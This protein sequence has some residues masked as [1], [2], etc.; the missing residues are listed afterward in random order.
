MTLGTSLR[1]LRQ[2][3]GLSLNELAT[4]LS[5][6][7]GNLS[8]IE[9]DL[10]KPSLDFLYQIAK[11][12]DFKLHEIFR[13]AERDD[14]PD[15]RQA[16]LDALFLVLL[17]DDKELLVEF[18]SMLKERSEKNKEPQSHPAD[19]VTAQS[20]A[21]ESRITEKKSARSSQSAA[22]DES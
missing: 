8:K 11:A 1:T 7:V 9:R 20:P 22:S 18:A 19:A 17:D 10:A 21:L 16:A 14:S 6:H 12:L 3:R 5:S 15:E 13:L 4:R 2:L